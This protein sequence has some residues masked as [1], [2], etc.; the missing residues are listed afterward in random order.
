MLRDRWLMKPGSPALA[1]NR[2]DSLSSSAHTAAQNNAH[3]FSAAFSS[4]DSILCALSQASFTLLQ[5]SRLKAICDR[6]PMTTGPILDLVLGR[7]V[8]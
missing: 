1:G 6:Y 7:L 2:S 4:L 5:P 3:S 8:F